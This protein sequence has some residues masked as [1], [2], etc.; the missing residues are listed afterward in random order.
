MAR[1]ALMDASCRRSTGRA[2]ISRERR[3]P[4][5]PERYAAAPRQ[6]WTTRR[7]GIGGGRECSWSATWLAWIGAGLEEQREAASSLHG[8]RGP[9]LSHK[10]QTRRAA[11]LWVALDATVLEIAPASRRRIICG[12][13]GQ[14]FVQATPLRSGPAV[15]KK[16]CHRMSST[17]QRGLT[18]VLCVER[19]RS[20][21]GSYRMSAEIRTNHSAPLK[22]NGEDKGRVAPRKLKVLLVSASG[23][24]SKMLL[25]PTV[26]RT[27]SLNT[28]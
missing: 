16:A 22:P 17:A 11:G 8:R 14:Q 21:E 4:A 3:R 13:C 9:G 20:D 25:A 15:A 5:S 23:R 28:G 1:T 7:N 18:A 19:G 12:E 10:R 24:L 2:S 6:P 27:R 26:T